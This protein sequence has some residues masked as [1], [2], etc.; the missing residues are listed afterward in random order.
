M[1]QPGPRL[2]ACAT[3]MHCSKGRTWLST[4]HTALFTL[5]TSNLHFTP[6]T[7]SSLIS[8]ELFSP[9]LSSS[10]LI[11][12]LLICQLHSS[13]LYIFFSFHLSTAQPFPSHRSSSQ[14]ISAPLHVRKLLL[15]EKSLL[16]T[17]AVARRQFLHRSLRRRCLYTEKPL[18]TASSYT[19]SFAQ[20]S[21]YTQQAFTQRSFYTE[22]LLH[23]EAST[24]SKLL[25]T[26]RFYTA[27]F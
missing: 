18:H 14:L 23:T 11:S 24:H 19:D 12:S 27:N 7:S 21:F 3:A 22:K 8:F 1:R 20:R 2:R 4:L 25:H 13:Q 5:H 10:H 16:H 17:K 15:S 26:A 6:H 9:H